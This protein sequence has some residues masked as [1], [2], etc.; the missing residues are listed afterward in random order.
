VT[1]KKEIDIATERRINQIL[2]PHVDFN[3]SLIFYYDETNNIR[4]FY[5]RENDFN[6]EFTK[7]FVLGGIV[8]KENSTPDVES[9]I[10]RLDL[11][12]S[13]KEIKLKHLGKGEFL[14]LLTSKRVATFLQFIKDGDLFIHYSSVNIFYWAIVDIVDSAIANSEVSRKLG[15]QFGNHLKNDLYK[16]CRL[17]IDTVV[18]LFYYYKYPNIKRSQITSFIADLTSLFQHHIDSFEFHFGLESLRQ[19]LKESNKA[20]SLPYIMDGDDYVL[21]DDLSTFYLRPICSFINSRHIFDKEDAID[22]IFKGYRIVNGDKE[23]NNYKFVDSNDSRMIQL[24]DVFI[25]LL[26]K[27]HDYVNT[28]V[29]ESIISEITALTAI[30]A[31]NIDLLF[32]VIDKSNSRNEA[33]LHAVDS[34]H[35]LSKIALIRE[36]RGKP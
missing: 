17:E 7:N 29:D 9:L 24:S 32:D 6:T 5:V 1:D 23:I 14:Q 31:S 21:V 28:R 22:E 2:A 3:E 13:V 10:E 15:P 18:D 19:I 16:L 27:M 25:G 26:G 12:K 20:E 30:Q 8:H 33:F 4:K 36:L 35:E 34:Y 11:Q